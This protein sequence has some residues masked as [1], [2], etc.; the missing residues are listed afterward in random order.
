MVPSPRDNKADTV[1]PT[2]KIIVNIWLRLPR[3]TRAPE[4]CARVCSKKR[5][6]GIRPSR[7]TRFGRDTTARE[8]FERGD[9]SFLFPELIN[10]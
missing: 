9:R 6:T 1:E 3:Q 10:W 5:Q 7:E 2:Y 4:I 8:I